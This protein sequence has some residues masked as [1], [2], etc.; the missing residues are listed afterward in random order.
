MSTQAAMCTYLRDIIGVLDTPAPNP[1]ARRVAIQNEGL[2]VIEDL[3]EFDDDGIK[4]LCSS[5]RKPGGLVV[6]PNDPN[7]QITNSG[8][9][10]PAI[11][12][13]RLKWAAFSAKVYHMIGRPISHDA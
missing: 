7:C 6:D 12:E 1:S 11:C 13:K 8:F 10:I 9:N 5:V 3:L 4:I 2:S